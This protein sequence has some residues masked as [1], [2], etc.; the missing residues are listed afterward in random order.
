MKS[1]CLAEVPGFARV[2]KCGACEDLH[3]A[4]GPMN[5]RIKPE[6][7]GPLCHVLEEAW[8]SLQNKTCT[9]EIIQPEL[10][11]QNV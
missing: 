11:A 2:E 3:V 7:L 6:A 5:I 9:P 10:S 1:Q 8:A 4:I